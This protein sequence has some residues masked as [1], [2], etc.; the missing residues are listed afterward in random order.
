MKNFSIKTKLLLIVMGTIITIS[1]LIA[2]MSIHSIH[3]LS[4][5]NI[6]KYKV[7]A[8]A[9]KK[10]ELNN[11]ISIA[12]NTIESY[13]KRI[14]NSSE[15]QIKEKVIDTISQIRY[16][17]NG[18][19]WIN[20]L[21]SNMIM[22]PINKDLI[23]KNFKG[24]SDLSF[25]D[26]SVSTL[27]SSSKTN[28]FIDYSFTTPSSNVTA[29]KISNVS[30][31]KEWG[32]IIGTGA[33]VDDIEN[34]I[35]KMKKSEDEEVNLIMLEIIGI[36]LLLAIVIIFIVSFISSKYISNPMNKFEEGLLS[37]FQYLNREKNE[38]SM[39]D[40][41]TRDEIGM[42][43]KI[44]NQNIIKTKTS[45]EE[46]RKVID[47]TINI[48][49]EFEQGDLCQRVD[50]NTSNPA[51]KELTSLLNQMGSTMEMNIDNVLNILEEYSNSNYMNKVET[52]GIKEHLLKLANGVNNLGGSI[53]QIL[54]ENKRNGLTLDE[55]SDILLHNVDILNKNSNES[56]A[57]L[58]QTAA[59]LEEMTSNISSNTENVIK[60]SGFASS[61][62]ESAND[63]EDLAT[64]TTTAMND[65][66]EKVNAIS[67][68]ITVIDQIAF[69]TNILSLNAA[70]EAATAGEAGKGFAVV[71]QEVR[72]LASRSAEAANEIKILVQNATTKANE[73][74]IISDKMIEGYNG[75]NNNISKTTELI[76]DVE[77]ASKEQRSGIEQINDAVNS[78][79]QQT[80]QNAMI[81]SQTNDIAT[82]TDSIAKLIVSNANAKEFIGKSN[83]K[84]KELS[85]DTSV[86]QRIQKK[87]SLDTKI[88]K[89]NIEQSSNLITDNDEWSSF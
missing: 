58:E 73:G 35:L 21:E 67:D 50:S 82:Q 87:Q 23:G 61:L 45:I 48:L 16:G 46:D 59:A 36:A 15:A 5:D 17:K 13:Q 65:I 60:M 2:F 28:A 69:Q 26:L 41:S 20:D 11:Y 70:V 4:N 77:N 89:S 29:S 34:N 86:N 43:A 40:E 79:D 78:L 33:Y 62:S 3:K 71:A 88:S 47:D 52:V 51:L 49:N 30:L 24:S 76:K 66:D 6:A 63:G 14:N 84:A 7:E 39:L 64:Q 56:A 75:L 83:V 32:W 80:Q 38:V 57:A 81:A 19:F 1:T 72:N 9:H 37:F 74:K 31:I 85:M 55:G 53:T 44:V 27:K 22:H 25:I 12:V 8:Y 54:V 10:A 18:Y 42:M 68:S